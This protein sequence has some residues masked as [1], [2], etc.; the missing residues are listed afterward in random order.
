MGLQGWGFNTRVLWRCGL[1]CIGPVRV[2]GLDLPQEI[3]TAAR[4]AYR[5][6]SV[7]VQCFGA[8]CANTDEDTTITLTVSAAWFVFQRQRDTHTHTQT[9]THVHSERKSVRVCVPTSQP[10]LRVCPVFACL[11][12]LLPLMACCHV[13]ALDALSCKTL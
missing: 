8:Q 3:V 12:S 5:R 1:L 6:V 7:D 10:P 9:H 11:S 4:F 13:T 2:G